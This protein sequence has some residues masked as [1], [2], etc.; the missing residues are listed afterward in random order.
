L[1]VEE[2]RR[3]EERFGISVAQGYGTS[4]TGWIAGCSEK[5]RRF[6]SVGMPMPYHR[7]CIV[8]REGRVCPPGETGQVE[9]GGFDGNAYRYVDEDG[10]IRINALGRTRTG[11]L[12]YLDAD[13]YLYL[14]GREKELI[15][16]GGVN[17]SPLEI[18]NLLLQMPGIAEAA[19]IG[20]PDRVYGEE[21]VSYVVLAPG[22]TL[23]ASDILQF[24]AER[25]AAFKAPKQIVLCAELPKT[26]RGKLDR[27][28]LGLAWQRAKQQG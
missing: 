25:I 1:L 20:V 17:I 9:V 18:D 2:W 8:D 15:I 3:F 11:D 5:T 28:A 16:R 24:C 23:A 22:A 21:V 10:E 6:G 14:T 13:G 12:G 26:E 7:L 4:E 19:T 27:K